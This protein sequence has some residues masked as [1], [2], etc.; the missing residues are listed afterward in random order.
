MGNHYGQSAMDVT[1]LG[2]ETQSVLH[3]LG[4]QLCT[5]GPQAWVGRLVPKS[6]T[7]E[8]VLLTVKFTFLIAMKLRHLDLSDCV[9]Q[10]S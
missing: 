8:C 3:I 5:F 6:V 4:A 1:L 7:F 2:Q 10:A 9:C